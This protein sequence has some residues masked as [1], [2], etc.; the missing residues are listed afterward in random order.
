MYVRGVK[1]AACLLLVVACGHSASE[2]PAAVT[3]PAKPADPAGPLVLI[4]GR[5]PE[6]AAARAALEAA[7]MRVED[8]THFDDDFSGLFLAF[9]D[10]AP[11]AALPRS[12]VP[13]W[14]AA[15]AKCHPLQ[16]ACPELHDDPKCTERLACLH[17]EMPALREAW[18]RELGAIAWVHVVAG[19]T[20]E[21]PE[22]FFAKAWGHKPCEPVLRELRAG[23]ESRIMMVGS[24][25]PL[26]PTADAAAKLAGELA[27]RI[28]KGEGD[29]GDRALPSYVAMPQDEAGLLALLGCAR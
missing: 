10:P 4:D 18:I 25:A 1:R 6:L 12:L 5:G 21:K 23:Q 9:P 3:P 22:V 16:D 2:P 26:P 11:P 17:G 13:R 14:Q 24:D 28:V 27:V 7:G 8:A 19:P 29:K 15:V 20:S